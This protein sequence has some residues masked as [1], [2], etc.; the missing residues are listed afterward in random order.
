MDSSLVS[1]TSSI[2]WK[3]YCS[4]RTAFNKNISTAINKSSI[5]R[6]FLSSWDHDWWHHSQDF[7]FVSADH[8]WYWHVFAKSCHD[9]ITTVH[10]LN[11]LNIIKYN[12]QWI[13]LSNDRGNTF[14]FDKIALC[15]C[16]CHLP[17]TTQLKS[18]KSGNWSIH[19]WFC[20]CLQMS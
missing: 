3:C 7:L 18:L 20:W 5:C 14:C 10:C 12:Q 2:S 9:L 8:N 6:Y 11:H 15:T 4:W 1:R 17:I 19:N 13:S 16:C